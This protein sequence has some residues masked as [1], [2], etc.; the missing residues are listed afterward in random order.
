MLD[1]AATTA[2]PRP[3]HLHHH[4]HHHYDTTML[5][6]YELNLMIAQSGVL[7]ARD[8]AHL[9]CTCQG[10]SS[11]AAGAAEC[12]IRLT[13]VHSADLCLSCVAAW[14]AVIAEDV[15]VWRTCAQHWLLAQPQQSLHQVRPL[16]QLTS[17][18]ELVIFHDL[19]TQQ[20]DID[21]TSGA[22]SDA[23]ATGKRCIPALGTVGWTHQTLNGSVGGGLILDPRDFSDGT[24]LLWT[25]NDL[26]PP[27]VVSDALSMRVLSTR[28]PVRYCGIPPLSIEIRSS[29]GEFAWRTNWATTL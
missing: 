4:H 26:D 19:V 24:I 2:A 10:T 17:W 6:P 13:N 29:V 23:G 9:A 21:L 28:I 3:H 5:L 15:R 22:I 16:H 7:S 14:R 25:S 8:L 18:R 27:L 11:V 12:L 1:G 20:F